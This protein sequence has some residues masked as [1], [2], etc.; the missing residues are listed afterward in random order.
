[1]LRQ[2]LDL[3]I[4]TNDITVLIHIVLKHFLIQH[5]LAI[6]LLSKT[7]KGRLFL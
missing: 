4:S 7:G 3:A 6:S 5:S 1:M 2:A